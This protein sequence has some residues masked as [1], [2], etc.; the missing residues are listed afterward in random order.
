MRRFKAAVA[1]MDFEGGDIKKNLKKAIGLIEKAAGEGAELVC[2]PEYLPTGLVSDRSD[3]L[4]ESI[5]GE[6]TELLGEAAEQNGVFV[7]FSMAE[8]FDGDLYNTA[9]LLGPEGEIIGKHRKMHRFLEEKEFVTPGRD[10]TVVDTDL[11]KLGLMVCYDAV[12]PE[13]SRN[14]ALLGAEVL[15]IP[16]NW[17][18]PFGPQWDLATSA[19]ALDNQVWVIAANR[20][21]AS[22]EYAYFG[23]SRIV[24]PT[25]KAAVSTGGE[26]GVTVGT[27]NPAI[28]EGFKGTINFLEDRREDYTL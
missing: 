2:L 19:R 20:I 11:G 22:E 18:D 27:V 15:L 1:Q 26:E 6:S 17:P 23:G 3:E 9:V 16:S 24:E 7:V 10:Y 12:F 25:G 13:L 4:S 14:L 8:K 28:T 5:P 21:G